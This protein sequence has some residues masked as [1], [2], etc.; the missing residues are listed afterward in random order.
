M[1]PKNRK[2][3]QIRPIKITRKYTKYAEGSV[4]IELGNTKVLCNATIEERVPK[5]LKGQSQGW[6]TAEYGMLPRATNLRNIREAIKG[7]QTGRSIE[8]QRLIARSLRATV[9]LKQ[10]GEYTI[11]LDCDVIQADGGTRTAAIS[12]A[13]VAL[14][15]ALNMISVK[16]KFKKNPIKSMV[17]A[18]SV[19]IVNGNTICDLEYSEDSIAETDMNIVMMDNGKII[20]IQGTAESKPFSHEELISLLYLAKNG[21]QII[22]SAQKQSLKT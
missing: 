16:E 20:E 5:F 13:H 3:D 14:T 9:D 12:G 10:L 4:L 19:G 17:A 21:L 11:I 22:F 7:G 15:D 2:A 1:R 18:I 8:I 6:I